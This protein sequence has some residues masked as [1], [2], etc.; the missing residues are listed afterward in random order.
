M[1][2][3]WF[4]ILG[5]KLLVMVIMTTNSIADV[6]VISD[7]RLHPAL[8]NGQ[9]AILIRGSNFT[10]ATAIKFI[11]EVNDVQKIRFADSFKI[12]DDTLI[13]SNWPDFGPIDPDENSDSYAVEAKLFIS[14]MD[15]K[16]T[17]IISFNFDFENYMDNDSN[18]P[19]KTAH[20]NQHPGDKTEC[21]IA[22]S[23]L[24]AGH[25]NPRSQNIENCITTYNYDVLGRIK[26]VRYEVQTNPTSCSMS[27]HAH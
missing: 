9:K 16:S 18:V 20:L 17:E 7:V 11:V 2:K 15:G 8:V 24:S 14:N 4:K 1:K 5:V 21:A 13:L 10:H 27:C 26:E 25:R 3:F 23:Q 19:L 6:P 12:I 22:G